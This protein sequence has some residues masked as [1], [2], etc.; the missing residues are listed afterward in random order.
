[1]KFG[2]ILKYNPLTQPEGELAWRFMYITGNTPPLGF[3]RYL[4]VLVVVT[5]PEDDLW[6][7]GETIIAA[8]V[9]ELV[10]E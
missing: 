8:G 9:N 3:S 4:R 1:M 7:A 5:D 2:D 6:I 10:P